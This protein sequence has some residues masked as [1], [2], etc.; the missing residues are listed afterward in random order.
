MFIMCKS[1]KPM[2][3]LLILYIKAFY[4]LIA[5]M[6]CK[7]CPFCYNKNSTCSN[8]DKKATVNILILKEKIKKQIK[9]YIDT[10]MSLITEN[11]ENKITPEKDFTDVFK[12]LE[13]LKY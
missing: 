7:S 12:K 5:S 2:Y 9:R 4:F 8:I 11:E 13:T 6:K 3:I 10:P 1:N